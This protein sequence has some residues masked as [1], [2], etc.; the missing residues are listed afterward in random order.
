MPE[1]GARK[2]IVTLTIVTGVLLEII[3]TTVVNVAMPNIIGALN[4]TLEDAAWIVTGY[5]I[6]N[7]IILPISGW[8]GDR[9]GRKKY[10]LI[11]ILLFTVMSL[12]CGNATTLGQ[13]IVFR[14][15][16]GLAGGGLLST[17]QAI[18][19]ETWP[20]EQFAMGMAIF[21][22]GVVVGPALGPTLGGYI[23]D[24]FSWQWIFYINLPVG[25]VAAFLVATFIRETPRFGHGDPIDW[26]GIG[27]LASF[28]G[29]LQ[30]VLEK[31]QSKDWFSSATITAF[32]AISVVSGIL[33]IWR[34]LMTRYPVVNLSI[35]RHRNYLV[36]NVMMFVLGL[37]MYCSMF[38]L[39][40]F[41]Q[42]ILHLTAQET[43]ML[44]IPSSLVSM[45]GMPVVAKLSQRG[46]PAQVLGAAGYILFFVSLAMMSGA[47]IETGA[48]YFFWPMVIMGI[49]RGFL[50]VPFT[51]LALQD[52]AGK[53]VGQGTGMNNLMRQ[54]G[55]SFGIAVLTTILQVQVG[56]FRNGL[57][58]YVNPY[59]PVFQAR[60]QALSGGFAA[61]G[62]SPGPA[63]TM[64][65]RAIEGA[66]MN[67]AQLLTY[68]KIY[69]GSGIMMLCCIGLLFFFQTGKKKPA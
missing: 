35:F 40:L 41:C 58:P 27:L 67:Q 21:G 28:V 55:G 10:F 50:M 30:M 5:A 31:G 24:H 25:L 48:G 39:P 43:G 45:V 14:V 62:F 4:A 36:G 15:L 16:Q 1:K 56:A 18:L 6:A 34:E 42:T 37:V 57:I 47:T 66:V 63:A 52:L 33:F 2:W 19:M 60:F 29:S 46:V 13:L 59:N 32:A 44:L 9:I 49:A 38:A 23:I 61:K 11:S 64:A 8:L 26:W 54:L 68:N 69:L 12:L 51:Q 20:K 22:I 7:V 65:L 53:E 17:G 3:D